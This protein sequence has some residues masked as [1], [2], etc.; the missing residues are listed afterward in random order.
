MIYDNYQSCPYC[1]ALNE[2]YNYA[3]SLGCEKCNHTGRRILDQSA[4]DLFATSKEFFDEHIEKC[5][6][7]W[8]RLVEQS[9]DIYDLVSYNINGSMIYIEAKQY[10][11]CNEYDYKSFR[12]PTKYL[13]GES[14]KQ[15]MEEEAKA[16]VA[17]REA[18]AAA[19]AE[20]R[21]L[22]KIEDDKQAALQREAHERAEYE[23][24]RQKFDK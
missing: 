10:A 9:N 3:E 21:R 16:I 2:E 23:R 7:D 8:Q 22:K 20:R 5:F 14:P 11:G 4:I 15:V 12:M 6:E 13:L 1:W 18:E 24:L 17:Q 19:A